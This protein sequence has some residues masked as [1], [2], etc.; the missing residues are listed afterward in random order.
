M[1]HLLFEFRWTDI[2]KGK[3]EI[4]NNGTAT[5][6]LIYPYT[7]ETIIDITA[8]TNVFMVTTIIESDFD[9]YSLMSGCFVMVIW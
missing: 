7:K 2:A 1:I 6:V 3:A 4:S 8:M 9:I 5:F